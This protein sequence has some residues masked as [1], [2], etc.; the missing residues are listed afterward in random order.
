V[1]KVRFGALVQ[2]VDPPNTFLDL[3]RLVEDLGFEYLWVADS[4]LHA[5]YVY[6]YLTL[7][8]MASQR[9]WLG[10]GVTHP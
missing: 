4:S 2:A 9:L 5:R 10:T 8:A 1:R 3:V 7:A 6:T